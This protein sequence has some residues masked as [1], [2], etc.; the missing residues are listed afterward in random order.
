MKTV[1]D[2]QGL[3]GSRL[4]GDART[5][6]SIWNVSPGKSDPYPLKISLAAPSGKRLSE[7]AEGFSSWKQSI[8]SFAQR[9][10][11]PVALENRKV[12]MTTAVIAVPVSIVVPNAD[13]AIAIVGGRARSAAAS[14]ANRRER[15]R[16]RAFAPEAAAEFIWKTR[17]RT[18]IDFELLVA[19]ADWARRHETHGMTPRELPIPDMQGKLLNPRGDRVLVALLA[20]KT[21]LGLVDRPKKV[22]VK[23]L[24]PKAPMGFGLCVLGTQDERDLARPPYTCRRAIIIENRDTFNSFPME[25]TFGSSSVA[26]LG[27][28][29]AG[30]TII[31]QIPWMAE[32]P[33]I[34]YWGDMDIDGLE[35]LAR[36]R[37]TGLFCKSLLMGYRDFE[38]FERYGTARSKHNMAIR[39]RPEDRELAEYLTSEEQRLYF[40]LCAGRLPKQRIEQEKI[41]YTEI[42][43]KA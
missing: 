25:G 43:L 9:M 14:C 8:M 41:P 32:I 16:D 2:I 11:C 6:Y 18:D 39:T 27:N 10:G 5:D 40:A 7:A 3:L 26:I 1:T 21:D 23:Y 33:D 38:R 29:N 31:K 34:Y 17:K 15:I 4:L 19:A 37:R 42:L 24:D 13:A 12:P 28:G 22:E 36:Y 35:I 30:P 20:G